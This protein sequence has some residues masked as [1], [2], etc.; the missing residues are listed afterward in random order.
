[1]KLIVRGAAAFLACAVVVG[2]LATSADAQ[3]RRGYCDRVARDY[4]NS[5]T[6]GNTVGGAVVGG[7][8]GAGVGALVGGG[9]AVGTGAA[10]G[11]GAGAVG[12][13]ANGSAAWRENYSNRY[14]SCMQG[15]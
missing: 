4:A 8:L 1:M 12:G 11:A 6:A 14:Y 9:H 7:L 2:A 5:Q 15:Y 13:A 3:S 10:I